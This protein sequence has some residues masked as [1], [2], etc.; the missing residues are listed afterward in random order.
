TLLNIFL[1]C[2]I[3]YEKGYNKKERI[4]TNAKTILYN[5]GYTKTT[6]KEIASYSDIPVSLV[7]YYFRK[8]DDIL[9]RI[10]RD[11]INNIYYYLHNNLLDIFHNSLLSSVLTQR[12]YYEIILRDENNS[13][14]H[15]QVL[16]N[17]SSYGM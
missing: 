1:R 13:R 10:Y 16:Q 9:K 7:H 17:R 3:M 11:F 6:I 14:V 12:I 4:Y 2:L 5:K 15:Y 8:K